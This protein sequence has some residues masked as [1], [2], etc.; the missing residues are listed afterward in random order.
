MSE[1]MTSTHIAESAHTR[2]RAI[3]ECHQTLL[4]QLA[5]QRGGVWGRD[6]VIL[7]DT[8]YSGTRDEG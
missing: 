6:Y 7:G 2:N 3:V 1:N 5:A 4:P 8:Q